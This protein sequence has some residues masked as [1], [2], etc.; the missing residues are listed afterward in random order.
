MSRQ[1]R[2]IKNLL[3]MPKI[4]LRYIY[5]ILSLVVAPILLLLTYGVI[6]FNKL[7]MELQLLYA[8]ESVVLI[9]DQTARNLSVAGVF[10]LLCLTFSSMLG[11]LLVSHRFVGPMY[12]INKYIKAIKE[13]DYVWE[14]SLRDGDEMTET[15][16]LLKE[17]GE[18]LKKKL[19]KSI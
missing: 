4:Q 19:G 6:Q 10:V 12:V 18:D 11:V 14:R 3:L 9:V 16:A 1:Q 7:S 17:L 2:K 8:S 5:Y 13:G 15:F